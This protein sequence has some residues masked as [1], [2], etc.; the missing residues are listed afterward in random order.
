MVVK[1]KLFYF[2]A[3]L[4][5]AFLFAPL[6]AFSDDGSKYA[7]EVL[8]KGAGARP[9][10]LGGAF[11]AAAS[12]A[13]AAYWNPA[14]LALIDGIEITTM[15]AAENELQSYDF[16]NL[17]FKTESAGSYA[18]SYLRLGVDG[19]YVTAD[20]PEILTTTQ[21]SDQAGL[22]SGGWKIGKQVAIG[23]TIK[24]LKTDAYTASA[25]GFGAD[26]GVIYK[27]MK[28]L[29]F[30][31]VVRDFTGGSYIQWQNTTTNPTQVLEPSVSIGA[32]YTQELGERANANSVPVPVSTLS[33][34]LDVDSLYAF[35][36]SGAPPDA[37]PLNNY[38]LGME[39]WYKQF[40]AVRGGIMSKGMQFDTDSFTPS[41]GV[42]VWAYL[43]ELDYAYINNSIGGI[44]YISLITRL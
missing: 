26:L 27:P 13:T 2:M 20:T 34:N 37:K 4:G 16:V 36:P 9:S 41:V 43:F 32:S 22:L 3:L 39:Y 44:H 30:G 35:L 42:G 10:A 12:D 11:V 29:S 18:I 25:F 40:V 17:A 1:S 14:G 7:A 23:G 31:L 33:I 5:A 38:H 8:T 21:Y 19:I 15:H 28:Q 6:A 24:L